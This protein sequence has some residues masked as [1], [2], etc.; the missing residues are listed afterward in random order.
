MA[1]TKEFFGKLSDGREVSLYTIRTDRLCA[2]VTD[3]GAVLVRLETPDRDGVMKDVVLGFDD[4]EHYLDNPACFGAIV[5]PSANRIA[6]ASFV[7]D[8]VQ[9]HLP[10]N[11]KGNNLHSDK[12]F[13][14]R[15][16]DTQ[17]G[18][19][20]VTFTIS[21]PDGD[22]GFPGN[23]EFAVKYTLTD[24]DLRIDYKVVSDKKT[25]INMTNHSYFNLAGEDSGSIEE[26]VLK[27]NC[28]GT[29]QVRSDLIPTGEINP[30]AG[31]PFDFTKEKPI[32]QDIDAD[33]EQLRFGGGYDHN[34]VIDGY[35][36]DGSLLTAAQVYDPGSGRVMET[37]TTVPGIQFYTANGMR[38]EGG[39]N[40]RTYGR[41]SGYALETQFFPDNVHHANFPQAVFGPGK[42]YEETTVYRFPA[43][44]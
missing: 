22:A 32:G 3:L 23:R 2:A 43:C 42:D 17:I 27:L 37:L 5:G 24:E 4:V 30:V 34:F 35:T 9:Y 19:N 10:V 6:G 44:R 41:R 26:Q 28:S 40:G 31:T 13:Y 15:L 29:T 1:V 20:S 16:F 25:V 38:V 12:M 11:E 8:G 18:E 14:K 39:K 36:G 33:D 21:L 7:I